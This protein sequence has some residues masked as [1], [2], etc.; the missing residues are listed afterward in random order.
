MAAQ[1]V[2]LSPAE[3]F[4]CPEN[5]RLHPPEQIGQI[6][7]SIEM[8]GFIAPV[9]VNSSKM[10]IA[11][12][13]RHQAAIRMG[14]KTIPC[15][16]Q[17]HLSAEQVKQ[18]MIIDNKLAENSMWDEY[19][20][21]KLFKELDGFEFEDFGFDFSADAVVDV[22]DGLDDGAAIK[23]WETEEIVVTS[24]VVVTTDIMLQPEIT[25]ILIEHFGDKV[26]F[27][28]YVFKNAKKPEKAA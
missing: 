11:G 4:P 25:R 5:P 15:L 28:R 1:I 13:G 16:V 2:N 21:Q 22:D 14:L 19:Q 7:K 17:D 6:V 12:H 10:I 8:F 24:Q 26:T 18:Y 20:L 27:E 9:V 23:E 3:I